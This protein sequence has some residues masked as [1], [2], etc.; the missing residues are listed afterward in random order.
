MC[1][2]KKNPEKLKMASNSVAGSQVHWGL[3]LG[4]GWVHWNTM[5]PNPELHISNS[6]L[7]AAQPHLQSKGI[8]KGPQN[9][10]DCGEELYMK[11]F[12]ETTW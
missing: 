5:L 7:K 1:K 9:S 2:K 3:V 4:K 10:H 6:C 8:Q 12:L 11:M